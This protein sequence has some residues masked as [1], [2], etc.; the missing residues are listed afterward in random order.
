MIRAG[1][2]RHHVRFEVRVTT[3]DSTGEPLYSWQTYH[4]TRAAMRKSPG[5]EVETEG[6]R[7]GRIPTEFRIRYKAGITPAMRLVLEI[8]NRSFNILSVVDPDGK[9]AELVVTCEENVEESIGPDGGPYIPPVVSLAASSITVVPTGTLVSVNVQA[10]LEELQTELNNVNANIPDATTLVRGL[11]NVTTQS[12][13]GNKTFTGRV[14]V[15]EF[16]VENG[17]IETGVGPIGSR[18]NQTNSASVEAVKSANLVALTASEDRYIHAFYRDNFINAMAWITA[19]GGLRVKGAITSVFPTENGNAIVL[20]LNTRINFNGGTGNAYM[21]ALSA[22]TIVVGNAFLGLGTV[23]SNVGFAKNNPGLLPI[24]GNVND[25]A[26]AVSIAL[27]TV[28]ALTTAGAKIVSVRNNSVEQ[29]FI[30]KD[31][32]YEVVGAGLGLILKSP[33]GT[34]YKATISN[35]GAWVIAAA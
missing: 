18:G 34:R 25:G 1:D 32:Q 7:Q 30:D 15:A 19:A 13:A 21:Y 6:E 5:N 3:Q 9:R 27:N 14:S 26:S 29:S 4:K 24:T 31:G 10:A 23:Y 28:P 2:L 35:A 20:P 8:Q 17:L 22:E 16:I 11:V 12:F 33:G